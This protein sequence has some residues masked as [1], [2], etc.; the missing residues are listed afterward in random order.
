MVDK[1]DAGNYAKKAGNDTKNLRKAGYYVARK[2]VL[3]ASRFSGT[4]PKESGRVSLEAEEDVNNKKLKNEARQ[5]EKKQKKL[6]Q[7]KKELDKKEADL[8]RRKKELE[9]KEAQGQETEAQ[10]EKQRAEL[11]EAIR[12]FEE[13]KR[14]YESREAY[15]ESDR[16]FDAVCERLER[17]WT[18]SY[19]DSEEKADIEI[20]KIWLYK[21]QIRKAYD[22]IGW[23][24]EY[25]LSR[26]DGKYNLMTLDENGTKDDL[27]DLLPEQLIDDNEWSIVRFEMLMSE[28][29][30]RKLRFQNEL[31]HMPYDN[32]L[33][34]G[35]NA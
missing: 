15:H 21:I 24:S 19:Y 2:G 8:N 6:S 23:Y 12:V 28:A 1:L 10:L 14:Q 16:R 27:H 3:A 20:S 22:D 4:L 7:V 17:G 5:L 26:E 29:E 30:K 13:E 33:L 9:E 11:E 18:L 25:T 31:S 32:K 35:D 34:S